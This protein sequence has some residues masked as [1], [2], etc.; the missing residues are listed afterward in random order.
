[1]ERMLGI[2]LGDAR[3]GLAISDELGLFASPLSVIEGDDEIVLN[4]ITD[5]T[6]QFDI[7]VMVVGLP[8]GLDGEE[9]A[10]CFRTREF[11]VKL[12]ERFSDIRVITW[13]ERFSTQEAEKARH[14]GRGSKRGVADDG[15][16]DAHAAKVI[17]QRYLD[18]RYKN[19]DN[20][21]GFGFDASDDF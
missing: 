18:W 19:G 12:Q 2:D 14:A 20:D 4:R 8:L 7:I 15:L 10:R 16:L 11:V 1:M 6:E 17:L 9:G 21:T 5:C 13:D 3:T